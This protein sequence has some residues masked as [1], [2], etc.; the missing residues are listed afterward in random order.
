MIDEKDLSDLSPRLARWCRRVLV[1]PCRQLLLMMGEIVLAVVVYGLALV[2]CAL[3]YL[4][5]TTIDYICSYD[6]P[7]RCMH[8]VRDLV[9]LTGDILLGVGMYGLALIG[10][11]L[12][13][14]V[15]T[16]L[17]WIAS[18]DVFIGCSASIRRICRP[19]TFLCYLPLSES[20]CLTASGY[21]F[22]YRAHVEGSSVFPPFLI[23]REGVEFYRSRFGRPP[24]YWMILRCL[25]LSCH[26]TW[27]DCT[28]CTDLM[29]A[30][31]FAGCLGE[32]KVV[33]PSC[34][35][36]STALAE[37]EDHVLNR[38]SSA[39]ALLR[40][41]LFQHWWSPTVGCVLKQATSNMEPGLQRI[42]FEYCH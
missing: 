36:V 8:A 14:I 25:R 5:M 24:R 9:L 33:R 2:G 32:T 28:V 21:G 1:D 35:M 7:V 38:I 6:L 40:E 27:V 10:Y 13:H 41:D 16:A 42:I 29:T 19:S 34:E 17:D 12:T 4:G 31:Q 11:G 20:S 37:K 3:L 23:R 22:R 39:R 18:W 26:N 30:D 15:M